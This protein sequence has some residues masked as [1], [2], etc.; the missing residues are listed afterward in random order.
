MFLAHR[1]LSGIELPP[2]FGKPQLERR[3]LR[4]LDWINRRMW[5]PSFT[6]SGL[7]LVGQFLNSR[8]RVNKAFARITH[9]FHDS[10]GSRLLR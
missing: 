9:N 8:V 10:R 1:M 4:A 6:S 7:S 3:H 2:E 5:R